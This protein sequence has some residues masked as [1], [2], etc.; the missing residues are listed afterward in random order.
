MNRSDRFGREILNG[1]CEPDR[2]LVFVDDGGTPGKP[3]DT[4]LGD[5]AVICGICMESEK[6]PLVKSNL[7]GLLS[8]LRVDEFH[9]TQ[10]VHPS[11][12]S[13]WRRIRPKKRRRVLSQLTTEIE[14]S[15]D[16][17][18]W[19]YAAGEQMTPLLRANGIEMELKAALQK[20]FFDSLISDWH[21]TIKPRLKGKE[22]ALVF[23]SLNPLGQDK[24]ALQGIR[25]PE[26]FYEGSLIHVDSRV[27]IG[28]QLADFVAYAINRIHHASHRKKEG[29]LNKFDEIFLDIGE[30]ILPKTVMLLDMKGKVVGD[31][32]PTKEPTA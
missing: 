27:E 26:G 30:R 21:S 9:A 25:D 28:I 19:C 5:Y 24:I 3:I 12:E 31:T 18:L 17:I 11:S 1:L 10:I 32:F 15:V 7:Q 14:E 8:E 4:L 13:S 6:Y 22:I 20:V 16:V 29:N 2:I 23:D